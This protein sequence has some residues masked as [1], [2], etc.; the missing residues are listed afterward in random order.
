[1]RPLDLSRYREKRVTLI[2]RARD[3]SAGAMIVPA[4]S[5]EGVPI[6]VGG[7]GTWGEEEGRTV[8]VSGIL[9]RRAVIPIATFDQEGSVS[10]GLE[11]AVWVIDEPDWQI[12]P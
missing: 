12:E 11:G 8:S 2:G 5:E 3:A 4:T 7:L 9:R 6:Y 10:H 1:M